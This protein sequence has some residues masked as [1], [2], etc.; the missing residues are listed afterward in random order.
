MRN[1]V[2]F[3]S[4]TSEA[5]EVGIVR[6]LP[7]KGSRSWGVGSVWA[8]ADLVAVKE[9]KLTRA[10]NTFIRLLS[11]SLKTEFNPTP[12]GGCRPDPEARQARLSQAVKQW[13][14]RSSSE[15]I[16]DHPTMRGYTLGSGRPAQPASGTLG[17]H[18]AVVQ[19]PYVRDRGLVA[20]SGR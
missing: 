3:D 16:L 6:F 1:R 11:Q 17:R 19:R 5:E 15:A 8:D 7:E 14:R 12:I 2:P 10:I 18:A 4:T 20:N 13:P 9:E